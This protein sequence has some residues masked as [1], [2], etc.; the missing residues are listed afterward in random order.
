MPRVRRAS[1]KRAALIANVATGL[2]GL[3]MVALA[4]AANRDWADAHFLPNFASSRSFQLGLIDA[5]RLIVAALGLIV[6]LVVRPRVARRVGAGKGRALLAS[7]LLVAVAV[8]ASLGVTEGILHSRTWRATQERWRST[9][10][11][12]RP[13]DL[14]GWTLTPNHDGQAE[15]DGRQIDYA[16]DR[17]SYRVRSAGAQTDPGRPTIVFAGESILL[18]Y[19]LQWPE[20]V[21]GQVEMMTGL[22][23]ANMS[24]NGYA[25]DQAFMR[26]RRE[27]P[28]FAHP[29]AVVIPFV[30]MLFDR[31][32]DEDRPHLDR[33]LRWQGA[34]PPPFRLAELARRVLH[35]RSADTIEA[36]VIATQAVLR[37]AVEAAR[38]RGALPLIVVPEY[39]PEEP[40]ERAIRVRVLD[41]G[42]I[43]YLLVPLRAD[44]RLRIDRH[45]NGRGAEAIARAIAAALAARSEGNPTSSR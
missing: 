14:T 36:G 43:P 29:V 3:V 22:Q 23:T 35:Y 40:T 15:T 33:Q 42:R 7:L 30:P 10:P 6:L 31:N 41:A 44:W 25:T 39:L 8:V 34:D 45:P 37:A 28:R 16:T 21:P 11:L 13:D 26:L 19:G 27:L 17:F 5:G 2:V 1:L 12:R 32:L 38:A 4:M 20:T 18:G 24:V 9:E